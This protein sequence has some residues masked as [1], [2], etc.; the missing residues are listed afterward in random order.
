MKTIGLVPYKINNSIIII[1]IV[2]Y[3]Y[4]NFFKLDQSNR[5]RVQKQIQARMGRS[6]NHWRKD[7]PLGIGMIVFPTWG[8]VKLDLNLT[9]IYKSK[10]QMD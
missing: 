9:T 2:L 4:K 8:Q 3:Q 10:F 6:I 1:K 5:L 7:W